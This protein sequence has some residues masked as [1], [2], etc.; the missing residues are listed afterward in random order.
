MVI[1]ERSSIKSHVM[2]QE[3]R[4]LNVVQGSRFCGCGC[5]IDVVCAPTTAS[6]GCTSFDTQ[7]IGTQDISSPSHLGT[8]L[9][10]T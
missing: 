6:R 3:C 2:I 4:S 8:R 9:F 10:S 5:G 7:A 1:R